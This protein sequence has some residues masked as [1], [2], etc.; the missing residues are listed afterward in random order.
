ML[1]SIEY[2]EQ[3]ATEELAAIGVEVRDWEESMQLC[4]ADVPTKEAKVALDKLADAR[5]WYIEWRH[6]EYMGYAID[7]FIDIVKKVVQDKRSSE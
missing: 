4:I 7:T 3:D 1:V 5:E 6:E 2:V